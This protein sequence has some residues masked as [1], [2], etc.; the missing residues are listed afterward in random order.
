[1]NGPFSIVRSSERAL[2]MDQVR[3][4]PGGR[5]FMQLSLVLQRTPHMLPVFTFS[6]HVQLSKNLPDQFPSMQAA[7]RKE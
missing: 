3:Q 1:M 6:E 4:G 7:S 5:W 2:L